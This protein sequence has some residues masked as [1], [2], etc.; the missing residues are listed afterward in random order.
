MIFYDDMRKTV[1]PPKRDCRMI[2][3]PASNSFAGPSGSVPKAKAWVVTTSSTYLVWKH[4]Q[5]F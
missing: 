3:L 2:G 5:H 4:V 1:H